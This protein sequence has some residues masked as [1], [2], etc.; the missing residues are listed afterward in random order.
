[1]INI[2]VLKE[3]IK[4]IPDDV[5]ICFGDDDSK[6]H[7]SEVNKAYLCHCDLEEHDCLC[8]SF[9]DNFNSDYIVKTLY[10]EKDNN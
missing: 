7:I 1:M 9:N 4:D 8:F 2:K 3:I 10:E 5:L 6:N